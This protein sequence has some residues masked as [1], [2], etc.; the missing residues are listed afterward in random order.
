MSA[1]A[2]A[3]SVPTRAPAPAGRGSSGRRGPTFPR[4]V[5]AEWSKLTSL[6]SSYAVAAATVVV[7]GVLTFLA[8]NA[9]SGDPGFDPRGSLTAG[10]ALAQIGPLVLGV[11][12]GTGE[13]STGTF[14]TT[15]TSV[16]RRVPVLLAQTVVTGA[17]ALLVAVLAVAAAVVGVLPAAASRDIALDLAGDGTPQVLAGTTALLAGTALLGLALGALVRR[18]VPAIVVAVVLVLVLPV[19][20]VLAGDIGTDP[21]AAA[22]AAGDVP[23]QQAAVNTVVT[24]LPAGAGQLLTMTPGTTGL[25]GAPDLG[26]WGGGLVLA[27]W[28]VVPLVV[29]AARLRVRDLA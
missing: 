1:P 15:F 9:S 5:A 3:A 12:V 2:T 28:V 26:P 14:R 6:R 21:M 29:A 4:V 25:D 11:L 23:A 16:P 17:L 22:P 13:F 10:V 18:P 7:S 24:L 19:V 27:A 20:L 8:A